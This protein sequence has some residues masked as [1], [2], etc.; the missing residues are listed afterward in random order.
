M[1]LPVERDP[2]AH[3]KD[4]VKDAPNVD[5]DGHITCSQE[6]ELYSYYRDDLSGDPAYR[7]D[8]A[9]IQDQA[10][11][12]DER[13]VDNERLQDQRHDEPGLAGDYVSGDAPVRPDAADGPVGDRRRGAD[14]IDGLLDDPDADGRRNV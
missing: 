11:Q 10:A 9:F 2:I 8:P 14:P 7:N 3:D 4:T 5:E 6:D 12:G 13:Y 1:S